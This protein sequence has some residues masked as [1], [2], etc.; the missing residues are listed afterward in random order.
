VPDGFSFCGISP[1]GMHICITAPALSNFHMLC[2]VL[3]FGLAVAAAVA[4]VVAASLFRDF[5]S[6]D[7]VFL[8]PL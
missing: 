2:Q 3:I 1:G 7:I 6:T 5:I 4:V 8:Q